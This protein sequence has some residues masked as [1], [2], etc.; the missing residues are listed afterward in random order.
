M[1]GDKS[2]FTYAFDAALEFGSRT[3][4][5]YA[6]KFIVDGCWYK[7]N[8]GAFNSHAEA[9]CS[10]LLEL[11]NIEEYVKYELCMVNGEFA[12]KSSDWTNSSLFQPLDCLY[13]LS[14]DCNSLH[15]LSYS[16]HGSALMDL[17]IRFA[18]R[19]LE[20]TDFADKLSLLLQFDAF[21][22]NEDRHFGN[23]GFI[24]ENGIW[25]MSPFYDF[26]CALLSCCEDLSDDYLAQYLK[27]KPSLPFCPTHEEQLAL[28]LSISDKRLNI[29]PFDAEQLI[30]GIWSE[31]YSIGK[32]Q[33]VEYFKA[34]NT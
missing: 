5:G 31:E 1:R 32:N 12:T 30:G 3:S 24:N 8:C 21:V 25:R 20:I 6:S 27:K 7:I 10:L 26:D 16:V 23:I 14:S 18:T 11:S 29:K 9:A 4:K 17:V 34:M 19:D 22:L 28:A 2:I 15:V 33:V 13:R